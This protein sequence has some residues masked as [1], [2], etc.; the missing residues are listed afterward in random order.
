VNRTSVKPPVEIFVLSYNRAEY[1]DECL[2][3][4]VNQTFRDFTVTVLDNASAQ[5]IE[6]VVAAVGDPRVRLVRNPANI[7]P[8]ANWLKAL[9]MA[10]ADFV[11]FFHDDDCL[12]PRLV[13][14]QVEL[15]R[16]HPELTFISTGVNLVNDDARMSVFDGPDGFSYEVI[17]SPEELLDAYLEGR[18]FG[19]ASILYRRAVAQTVRPDV[20]RFANVGDRVYMLRLAAVGPCARLARPTY[21]VR[22]HAQQDSAVQDWSYV[23]ELELFRYYAEVGGRGARLRSRLARKLAHSYAARRQRAPLREWLVAVR[24]RGLLA[25]VLVL[26]LPYY[27]ARVAAV[28]L[29][30]ALLPDLYQRLQRAKASR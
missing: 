20:A 9:D 4:I 13:E 15:F 25:P 22:V 12:S 6:S 8:A 23:H 26:N 2:R 14:R 27:F 17:R 3:S 5:D 21:N 16:T 10:S 30:R 7:G 24:A 18:F 29:G 19:F 11:M 28:R 1:L